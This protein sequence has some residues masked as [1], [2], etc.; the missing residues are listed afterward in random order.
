MSWAWLDDGDEEQGRTYTRNCSAEQ[1][2]VGSYRCRGA[3]RRARVR[4]GAGGASGS[5][6]FDEDRGDVVAPTAPVGEL[7]EAV[8]ALLATAVGDA[9][10]FV[11]AQVAVQPVGAQ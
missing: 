9:G 8:H 3:A 7:D 2:F 4:R 5:T 10:Y 1:R 11:G 6:D